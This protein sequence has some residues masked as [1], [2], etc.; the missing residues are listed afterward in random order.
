M[1]VFEPVFIMTAGGPLNAT[2]SIVYGV[3]EAAFSEFRMGYASAIAF[4][5]L[6]MVFAVTLI[7]LRIGRTRWTY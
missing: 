4:V 6:I 2:R 7:Q 3:Y 5:L 1:Q